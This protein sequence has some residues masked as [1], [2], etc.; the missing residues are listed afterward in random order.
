MGEELEPHLGD[1]EEQRGSGLAPF[2]KR[3]NLASTKKTSSGFNRVWLRHSSDSQEVLRATETPWTHLPWRGEGCGSPEAE[4]GTSEQSAP[5]Q[6][7]LSPNRMDVKAAVVDTTLLSICHAWGEPQCCVWGP[8]TPSWSL[9]FVA[10][11]STERQP[12]EGN[13]SLGGYSPPERPAGFL[14]GSGAESLESESLALQ[15]RPGP[16]Q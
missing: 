2:R 3:K 12:S 7:L 15:A 4:S 11:L 10:D 6:I 14:R 16:L 9:E 5:G 13:E 8:G 1:V